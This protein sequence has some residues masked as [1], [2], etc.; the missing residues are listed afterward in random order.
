MKINFILLSFLL[1]CTTISYS[2]EPKETMLVAEGCEGLTDNLELRNCFSK[3]ISKTLNK[4]V[5]SS[6]T[7]TLNP[8]E[9][10]FMVNIKVTK[11]QNIELVLMNTTNEKTKHLVEKYLNKIKILK[12]AMQKGEPVSVLFTFPLTLRHNVSGPLPVHKISR[13]TF[14]Y[15]EGNQ[16]HAIPTLQHCD[17]KDHDH[18]YDKNEMVKCM[19]SYL[20]NGALNSVDANDINHMLKDGI[21]TIKIKVS[22]NENNEITDV[23]SAS[24][25]IKLDDIFE[26]T[27]HELLKKVRFL[28]PNDGEKSY[29]GDLLLILNYV[30]R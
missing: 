15:D 10:R 16:N 4:Q 28:S 17:C 6:F 22:H 14:L 12:P 1:L 11:D 3:V 24:G 9:S 8:G 18:S 30:K 25:N 29:K 2:Q 21:N 26:N 7:K 27:I 20:I 19:T 5:G 23:T 13:L